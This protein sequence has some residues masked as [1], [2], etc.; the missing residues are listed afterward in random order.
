[1]QKVTPISH[2]DLLYMLI[3]V[4]TH[5]RLVLILRNLNCEFNIR[6]RVQSASSGDDK[7]EQ[8]L[9]HGGIL[10]TSMLTPFMGEKIKVVLKARIGAT[11]GERT[12]PVMAYADE[13]LIS[14]DSVE[15]QA[16]LDIAFQYSSLWWYR[17]NTA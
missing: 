3:R 8:G 7:R 10:S 1:M 11:I 9:K 6:V 16:I 2:N 13:V 5:L 4:K 15:L 17:Y 14:T 12:V